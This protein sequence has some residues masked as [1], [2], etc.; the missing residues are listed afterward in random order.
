MTEIRCAVELRADAS[1]LT[2]GRLY[3]VLM[4]EGTPAGD[5]PEVFAAGSLVWPS[6]G[7][8]LN[9]QHDRKQPIVRVTPERRGA[10]VVIDAPLPDTTAGRD[11]ATMIKNG[12]LRGLSVEF[13]S[14]SEGRAAGRRELRRARLLAAGLVDDPSYPASRVE[15]RRRRLRPLWL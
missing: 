3:G 7:V 2:P 9:L 13:R 14:E 15:V 12:T 5:R 10:D 4:A 6:N 8:V 11:A 1:R